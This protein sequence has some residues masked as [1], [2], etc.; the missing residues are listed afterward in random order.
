MT[1]NHPKVNLSFLNLAASQL[2]SHHPNLA[3]K[4]EWALEAIEE[5][6]VHQMDSI[7]WGVEDPHDDRYYAVCAGSCD[8]REIMCRHWTAHRI[9]TDAAAMKINR[10]TPTR[11]ILLAR[12]KWAELALDDAKRHLLNGDIEQANK[13]TFE[14]MEWLSGAN[15]STL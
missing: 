9:V 8:C 3:G 11:E 2:L 15:D 6:R 12:V 7:F 10:P 1:Q 4:I 14:A 13:A 5:E